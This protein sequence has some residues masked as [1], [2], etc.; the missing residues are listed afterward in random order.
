MV[1]NAKYFSAYFER[2][3]ENRAAEE[4][5]EKRERVQGVGAGKATPRMV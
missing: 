4:L 3:P 2:L 1:I 5:W